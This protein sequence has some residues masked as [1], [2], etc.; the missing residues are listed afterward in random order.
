MNNENIPLRLFIN[1]IRQHKPFSVPK[2]Q[3]W[4]NQGIRIDVPVMTK[5]SNLLGGTEILPFRVL[6][7][8]ALAG[9]ECG[10]STLVVDA[11]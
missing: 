4:S 6:I 11:R 7:T 10:T 8:G 2:N 9:L 5:I 3:I 1:R